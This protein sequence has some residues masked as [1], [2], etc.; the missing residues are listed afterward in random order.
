MNLR[1]IL[2]R[3]FSLFLMLPRCIK[4]INVWHMLSGIARNQVVDFL[5]ISLKTE[6]IRIYFL[7]KDDL[8]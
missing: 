3:P 5:A 1:S 4:I 7:N 6:K 2:K 8:S